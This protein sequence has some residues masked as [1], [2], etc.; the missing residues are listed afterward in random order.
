[1]VPFA[2]YLMPLVYGDVGQ[3]GFSQCL[4]ILFS[5]LNNAQLK[6]ITKS[7]TA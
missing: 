1:M 3:G 6:V 5:S 4:V 2:G 7:E